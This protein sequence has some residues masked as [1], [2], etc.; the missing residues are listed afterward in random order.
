M[1]IIERKI[2]VTGK[3]L[4]ISLIVEWRCQRLGS[5]NLNSDQRNLPSLNN[6]ENRLG[7]KEQ[8]LRDLQDTSKRSNDCIVTEWEQG[9]KIIQWNSGWRIPKSGKRYKPVDSRSWTSSK[10]DKLKEIY[11]YMKVKFLENKEIKI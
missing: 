7:K 5:L 9:W 2:T 8:R 3:N 1:E 11:A 4:R 6:K 10:Q